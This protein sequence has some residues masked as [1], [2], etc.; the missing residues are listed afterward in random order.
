MGERGR[1]VRAV[2]GYQRSDISDQESGEVKEAKEVEEV[3]EK[4][5]GNIPTHRDRRGQRKENGKEKIENRNPR[6]RHTVRAWGTRLP[7][8]EKKC[9]SKRV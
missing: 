3:K 9:K 6:P 8:E 5:H 4:R 2:E 7:E 1:L